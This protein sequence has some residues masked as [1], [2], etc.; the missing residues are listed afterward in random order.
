LFLLEK[1]FV[2]KFLDMRAGFSRAKEH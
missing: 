2:S 1:Q